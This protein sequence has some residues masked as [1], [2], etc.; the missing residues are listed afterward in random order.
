M[1]YLANGSLPVFCPAALKL[2]YLYDVVEFDLGM[3][4]R[5]RNVL[6][7]ACSVGVREKL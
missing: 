1:Y 2:M 4:A 5:T 6:K 7:F 3:N